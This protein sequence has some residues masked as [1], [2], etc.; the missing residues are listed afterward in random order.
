MITA[1]KFHYRGG[2]NKLEEKGAY[3]KDVYQRFISWYVLDSDERKKINL[4][5]QK[6]FAEKYG[7]CEKTLSNWADS[8]VF[9]EA[10][11]AEKMRL[12]EEQSPDM[13]KAF[14]T[15]LKKYGYAY[16]VELYL[17]Y[18]EKWDRKQVIE[19]ANEIQL[20][21]GDI[22]ALVDKLPKEKQDLFYDTLVDIFDEA[23]KAGIDVE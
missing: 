18:V 2:S 11:H 14:M 9:K 20:S 19:F 5:N 22:R 15:R 1:R 21:K 17:A 10:K 8:S 3:K 13:W 6:Q 4:I 7:V 23:K 16:E 12:L